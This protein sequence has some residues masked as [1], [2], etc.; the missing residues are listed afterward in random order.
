MIQ[1]RQTVRICS[2][3]TNC[4]AANDLPKLTQWSGV[5]AY[6]LAI[7]WYCSSSDQ[8]KQVEHA[9][10]T[11]VCKFSRSAQPNLWV[12][13]WFS[14]TRVGSFLVL[15]CVFSWGQRKIFVQV[16]SLSR[17]LACAAH[18]ER[19]VLTSLVLAKP[20]GRTDVLIQM[21]YWETQLRR[22]FNKSNS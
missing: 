12:S 13:L 11:V 10:N 14:S 8:E 9:V 7:W 17:M 20:Q 3:S 18:S 15:Y 5:A 4:N 2:Q 21:F 22:P 1:T 19:G 6:F 16:H